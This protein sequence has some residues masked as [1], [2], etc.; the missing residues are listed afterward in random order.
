MTFRGIAR[1]VFYHHGP[2]NMSTPIRVPELDLAAGHFDE[3]LLESNTKIKPEILLKAWRNTVSVGTASGCL[4]QHGERLL[5]LTAL[6]VLSFQICHRCGVDVLK[7]GRRFKV[8]LVKTGTGSPPGSPPVHQ[9]WAV[10]RFTNP[11]E[12]QFLRQQAGGIPLHQDLFQSMDAFQIGYPNLGT[13]NGLR[14]GLLGN[15]TSIPAGFSLTTSF[16]FGMVTDVS[17][18]PADPNDGLLHASFDVVDGDSGSP[19]FSLVGDRLV[20]VGICSEGGG[21]ASI[22]R[23]FGIRLDNPKHDLESGI[24]VSR[25]PSCQP[26]EDEPMPPLPPADPPL[27]GY[28]QT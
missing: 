6:H 5:L 11:D 3:L 24:G 26:L 15:R 14:I 18:A 20:I 10:L 2:I 7:F 12:E 23:S 16:Q 21:E 25:H 27:R 19:V 28:P 22:T 17:I 9:D 8:Q 13:A 4:V 1:T